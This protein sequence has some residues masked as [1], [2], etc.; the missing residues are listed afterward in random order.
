MNIRKQALMRGWPVFIVVFALINS[1]F[2]ASGEEEM[3]REIISLPKPILKGIVS[4]E[5][6]ILQR[7]SVRQ[8][9]DKK[10]TFQQISQLL[11]AAQ[12]I[13]DR[14]GLRTTPS[15]GALFPLKIYIVSRNGFFLY[16]PQGHKL[17]EISRKDM[18]SELAGAAWGQ[19][20]IAEAPINIIIS[21]VYERVTSKYGDR[22]V[23]YSDIEA[24]HAAQNIHL[25][26]VA[27][28]LA[29]IAI[30]A[31]NDEEVYSLLGLSK[32]ETPLYI[33]PVGYR[34]WGPSG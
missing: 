2:L 7:R 15:A 22:G 24:G 1:P 9:S 28:G 26:A 12:G 10:M 13:T 16:R 17:I 27:L 11:W 34:K 20:F 30:A 31:F 5:E 4:I 3:K 21:A 32:I 33:I 23:R 19:S 25:Q 8:Y 29:S 18:R 14:R 6:T